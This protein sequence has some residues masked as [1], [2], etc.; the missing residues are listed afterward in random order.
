MSRRS[1]LG[2]LLRRAE[3]LA[4]A[5]ARR[6][7]ALPGLVL[8]TRQWRPAESGDDCLIRVGYTA[9]RRVGSAVE[10]NRARRRLRAAAQEILPLRA[11]HRHDFVLIA[12]AGTNSR[13]FGALKQD[14]AMA[15]QRVGADRKAEAET[16]E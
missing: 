12:R 2:R 3:F 11:A 13:P 16:V 14:L 7:T 6:K 4:V 8:Q 10:R 5:G 15:L 9:S 1:G